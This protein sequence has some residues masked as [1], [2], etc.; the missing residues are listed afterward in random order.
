MDSRTELSLWR[1]ASETAAKQ[2]V[3]GKPSCKR[4]RLRNAPK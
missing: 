1:V 2:G 4:L 3:K